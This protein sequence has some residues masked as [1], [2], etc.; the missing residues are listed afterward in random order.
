MQVSPHITVRT[1]HHAG[2]LE[3]WLSWDPRSPSGYDRFDVNDATERSPASEPVKDWLSSLV[4]GYRF[5]R[6]FLSDAADA[7]GWGDADG[8]IRDLVPTGDRIRKGVLGEI[9]ACEA[10]TTFCDYAIPV[11]K[12]RF[13]LT[14]NQSLPA[15]DALGVRLVEGKI[16]EVVFIEAKLR[17][18][19]DLAVAATAHAQLSRDYAKQVPDILVFVGQRLRDM[20]HELYR[21]FMEYLAARRATQ[22][23]TFHVFVVC[24][25]NLW[26]EDTL[27]RL[28]EDDPLL[29]PL[30]VSALRVEGLTR[31][32]EDAFA[33][34]GLAVAISDD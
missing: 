19:T 12:L 16:E 27:V 10:L 11:R 34:S 8:L 2:V 9:L 20:S 33:R 25:A 1:C 15:T 24:E 6:E 7:L 23:D 21:P 28:D 29:A 17:T 22:L 3:T 31:L 4:V 30:T 5:S 13:A 14:Q 26:S 32:A 18:V